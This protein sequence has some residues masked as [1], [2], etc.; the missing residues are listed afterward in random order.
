M[1]K[2]LKSGASMKQVESAMRGVSDNKGRN[3]RLLE[4]QSCSTPEQ[5][6]AVIWTPEL[7]QLMG[8]RSMYKNPFAEWI[9][10]Y[11]AG[12]PSKELFSYKTPLEVA[13]AVWPAELNDPDG[14]FEDLRQELVVWIELYKHSDVDGDGSI[15]K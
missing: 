14:L 10:A 9:R 4:L 3:Q 8:D 5:V 2:K 1:T 12:K 11:R 15:N 7:E 6:A 13:N